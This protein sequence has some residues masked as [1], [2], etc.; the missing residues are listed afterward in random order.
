[1]DYR[2]NLMGRT[3]AMLRR[4]MG[5]QSSIGPRINFNQA[6]LKAA[7]IVSGYVL[8]FI[9]LNRLSL[10]LRASSGISLKYLPE[11]LSMALLLRYGLKFGPLLIIRPFFKGLW[12][13]PSPLGLPVLIALGSISVVIYTLAAFILRKGLKNDNQLQDLK[14]ILRFVG[15]VIL[16]TLFVSIG[17]L[18]GLYS[19]ELVPKNLFFLKM[20][21]LWMGD[22]LGI[23]S[24][25]PFLLINIFPRL[26]GV[27]PSEP[28]FEPQGRERKTRTSGGSTRILEMLLQVASIILVLAIVFWPG[29]N[30]NFRHFYFCFIPIIWIALRH[31]IRGATFGILAVNIGILLVL[32]EWDAPLREIADTQVFNLTITLTSLFLGAAV[33]D[34]RKA[35]ATLFHNEERLRQT[36]KMEVVER[37]VGGI[38]HDFNNILTTING[39]CDLLLERAE[40]AHPFRMALQE[41]RIAGGRAARLTG[42]LLTI[43]RK[44]VAANAAIDLNATVSL[45]ES[46]LRRL[47]GSQIE[48]SLRLAPG[49]SWIKAEP[50]QLERVVLNLFL[51]ANEAMPN[52]GVLTIRTDKIELA[53]DIPCFNGEVAIGTYMV[54]TVSDT[55]IGMTPEL[56]THIFEPFFTTKNTAKGAGLGLPTVYGIVEQAGGKIEFRSEPGKGSVFRIY[57]KAVATPASNWALS[58]P[59]PGDWN[60]NSGH[61]WSRLDG[62]F[63]QGKF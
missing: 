30:Q 1:M 21:H 40:P 11:G 33:S 18:S 55:G 63:G 6:W 8:F 5:R 14:G 41:I 2:R 24:L 23:I 45:M 39:Y 31:G 61:E 57:F 3:L 25:T 16:S 48:F 32:S 62:D 47:T 22:A 35:I 29:A 58:F 10:F 56:Q 60:E 51:N 37:L 26:S 17:T 53:K 12:I 38:A 4:F 52:G 54:L 36:Q 13:Y 27:P 7:F 49:P 43:S 19:M 44:R 50:G 46:T 59:N 15:V 42:D 20:F 34:R 9:L 28:E